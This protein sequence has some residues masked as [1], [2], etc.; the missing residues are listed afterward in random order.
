MADVLN[1]VIIAECGR[2]YPTMQQATCEACGRRIKCVYVV[3]DGGWTFLF[4]RRCYERMMAVL[5]SMA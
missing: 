5:R 3:D 2:L 4:G 1:V